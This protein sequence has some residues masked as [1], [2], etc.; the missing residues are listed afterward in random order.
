MRM[1]YPAS[2]DNTW[3]SGITVADPNAVNAAD[4]LV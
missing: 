4:I 2:T 1:L 3:L